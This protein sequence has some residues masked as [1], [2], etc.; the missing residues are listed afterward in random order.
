MSEKKNSWMKTFLSKIR[1]NPVHKYVIS[2]M[3]PQGQVKMNYG[4]IKK[5]SSKKTRESLV[6]SSKDI[7]KTIRKRGL[8]PVTLRGQVKMMIN[9]VKRFK[10][11][12]SKQ[13]K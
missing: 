11:F 6:K 8:P 4:A 9:S 2:P 7:L 13:R 5:L 3:T 1:K 10:D 12:L